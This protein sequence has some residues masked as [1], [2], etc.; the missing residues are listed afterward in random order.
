MIAL[1]ASALIAALFH[2]KGHERV[3][4][5][6]GD[7]CI[8]AVNVSEVIGRFVRE[9]YDAG[10]ALS[11]ILALNIEIVPFDATDATLT[12]SLLPITR[13]F[14][15]S[16]GDRACLALAITRGIGVMTTDHPW[17]NVDLPIEIVCIR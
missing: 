16:L 12:A 1:D 7:C 8:S 9:G 17:L 13:P 4:D 5:V 14:G 3:H 10:E 6:I 2:E 15:L 11:Q